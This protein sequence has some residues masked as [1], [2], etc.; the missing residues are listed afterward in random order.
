MLSDLFIGTEIK[1]V[2]VLIYF[3][4]NIGDLTIFF[5]VDNGIEFLKENK[6]KIKLFLLNEVNN[7]FNMIDFSAIFFG[8]EPAMDTDMTI[9]KL[10]R[11]NFKSI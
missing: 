9:F 8:L 1:D 4:E 5:G 2:V 3:Y 10:N 11:R 6:N 7:I